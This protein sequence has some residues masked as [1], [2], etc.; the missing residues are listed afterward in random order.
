MSLLGHS[1]YSTTIDF[2]GHID[3]ETKREATDLLS[4]NINI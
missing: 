4:N 1:S 3:T 2:Y